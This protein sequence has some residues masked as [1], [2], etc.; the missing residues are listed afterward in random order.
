MGSHSVTCHPT[1]V[2]MHDVRLSVRLSVCLSVT[3]VD[4]DHIGWKSWR[5]IQ[6]LPNF[7]RVPSII[8]GTSKAA[9]FKFCRHSRNKSPLKISGKVAVG[10]VKDSRKFFGH[11]YMGR[12]AR[13]SLR[14]LSFL[15]CILLRVLAVLVLN[16]MI[17][18]SR[19]P[20]PPSPP[21]SPS[22]SSSSF[23]S[24]S[25]SSSANQWRKRNTREFLKCSTN[26][27]IHLSVIDN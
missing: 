1:Q 26:V 22:S 23:S 8:S 15:V 10:I 7:F 11:P 12:I 18:V 17:K 4:Q 3:L 5:L 25:S 2:N 13:S 9:Y 6:G 16:F 24:S 21:P 19:P 14:W 27:I 20:P